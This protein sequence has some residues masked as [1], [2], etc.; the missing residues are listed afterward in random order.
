MTAQ[1]ITSTPVQ[2][3]SFL[4]TDNGLVGYFTFNNHIAPAE[5]LLIEAIKE[6]RDQNIADL[7]ID[8]RYNGGGFLAIA[9][10][11]SSMIA[12]DNA[13]GQIF[14]ELEFNSKHP[15]FN[16]VTGERISPKRF[17]SV[18]QG[19]SVQEG[20]PLPRLGL[21][22]VFIIS[23]SGTCSASESIINGLRGIDVEVIL[24]GNTTCG[25]PYGFYAFDNCGTTYFSIQFKGKNNKGFGD[26][27]DGFSPN[28]RPSEAGVPIKGCLVP[29]DFSHALGD[30]DEARLKA[31]LDYRQ[32]QTC[33]ET[34]DQ[35]S[36]S[37]M[38]EFLTNEPSEL[39]RKKRLLWR[40]NRIIQ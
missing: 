23:G 11:L 19:F 26:Y 15:E 37:I 14:E 33:P 29:D 32:S 22:R 20:T 17:L 40:Q 12:G 34:A 4:Q 6:I 5:E 35:A 36:A 27:S 38:P 2:N 31:V 18:T 13:V 39:S 25:K 10:E 9:N 30:P 1:E 7:V 21:E 3:L 8:L 16:P 28:N 24:V